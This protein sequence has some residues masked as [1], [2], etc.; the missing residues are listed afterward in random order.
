MTPGIRLP[1][2]LSCLKKS[3]PFVASSSEPPLARPSRRRR[4]GW[5]L[6]DTRGS[7]AK[8]IAL[9]LVLE[10]VGPVLR[11]VGNER[12]VDLEREDAVVVA[13]P[14]AVGILDVG[15]DRVPRRNLVRRE[16]ALG[17]A[18]GSERQADVS[19]TSGACGPLLS[20]LVLIAS[21]SSPEPASGLSSLT[22]RPVRA[23]KVSITLFGFAAA[24][25]IWP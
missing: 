23:L 11:N 6:L 15:R 3:R 2:S 9:V 5:P 4:T 14:G 10:Q 24:P 21:I 20:L 13:V 8:A 18:R 16:Q 17:L 22:F 19:T 1:L 12:R 7:P 25:S